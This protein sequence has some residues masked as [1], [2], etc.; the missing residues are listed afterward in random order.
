MHPGDT[1]ADFI[2]LVT[3]DSTF[4][5]TETFSIVLSEAIGATIATPTA[6]ATILEWDYPPVVYVPLSVAGGD[7]I[8]GA[9]A[10]FT[11]RLAQALSHGVTVSYATAD[12][13]A[14]AP[15]D[16]RAS[17]RTVT[18]APGETVKF[19]DIP[20]VDDAQWEFDETFT[21][22]LGYETTPGVSRVINND[23]P[24]PPKTRAVRH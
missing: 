18:F 12:G 23:P 1:D 3:N 2:V 10:R 16:Y 4:E 13:S 6:T 19:V 22:V 17:S 24:P 8:E 7:V 20:T 11:I 14:V 15:D 9:P 5:G 21:L